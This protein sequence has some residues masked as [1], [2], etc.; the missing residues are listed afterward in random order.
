ML[1][2]STSVVINILLNLRLSLAIC[3]FIDGHF[4]PLIEVS[5][6]NR[7]ERGVLSVNDTIINRPESV[8]IKH[9]FVPLSNTFHLKIGLV[10]NAVVNLEKIDL[11]HHCVEFLLE[12]VSLETRKEGTSVVNPLDKGVNC[13]TISGN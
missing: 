2:S 13:I 3:W 4:Y 7:S 1:N 8:E 11:R 12:M 5:N 6:H 9:L 10:S